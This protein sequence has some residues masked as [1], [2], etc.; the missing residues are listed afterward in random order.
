M[1]NLCDNANKSSTQAAR[2][3]ISVVEMGHCRHPRG[4]RVN[5]STSWR[6][7]YLFLELRLIFMCRENI[8]FLFSP[9]SFHFIKI[10]QENMTLHDYAIQRCFDLF[11][12]YLFL[13]VHNLEEGK[14][15]RKIL[16]FPLFHLNVISASLIDQSTTILPHSREE[17]RK[18]RPTS[19]QQILWSPRTLPQL[20]FFAL[21]SQI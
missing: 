9:F 7:R 16:S 2:P 11:N 3:S 6:D 17:T 14:I 1:R 20:A 21:K 8:I 12:I 13:R 15:Y 4:H 10:S 5:A 19:N 18:R